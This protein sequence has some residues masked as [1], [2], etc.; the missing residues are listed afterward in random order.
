M[1]AGASLTVLALLLVLWGAAK[2]NPRRAVA[3]AG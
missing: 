1:H 3:L 2:K